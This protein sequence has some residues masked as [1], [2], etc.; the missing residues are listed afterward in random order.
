MLGA[1]ASFLIEQ[2]AP[3]MYISKRTSQNKHALESK[4]QVK[5]RLKAK[6]VIFGVFQ[7]EFKG[8]LQTCYFA[9]LRTLQGE[10]FL[11]II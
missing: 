1:F 11:L 4:N 10:G 2:Q 8:P 7:P 5:W 3:Y 9:P 6:T